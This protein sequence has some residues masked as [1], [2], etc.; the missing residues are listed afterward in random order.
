[1]K[2]VLLFIALSAAVSF[3]LPAQQQITKFAIVDM[4]KVYT[5]FFNESRAVQDFNQKSARVQ[6]EINRLNEELIDL[7]AK[8]AEAQK[9]GN[10][11]QVRSLESQVN[12]KTRIIQEYYQSTYAELELERKRLAQSDS[13]KT[14]ME[15]AIKSLAESEGIS[16]VLSKQEIAGILW[17]SPSVDLTNKLIAVLRNRVR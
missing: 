15:S 4:A 1:M 17:Y 16:M 2:R 8:L 7:K 10:R 5:T 3:F 9:N 12:Q 14:Q 6:A 11:D 13:F